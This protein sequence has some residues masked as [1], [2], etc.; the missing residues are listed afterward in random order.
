MKNQDKDTKELILRCYTKLEYGYGHVR[1][2][3]MLR[4]TVTS[5]TEGLGFWEGSGYRFND[6]EISNQIDD[7]NGSREG[8][9][10]YAWS[11]AFSSHSI[12]LR[13]AKE[14]VKTLSMIDRKLEAYRAEIGHAVTYGQ[15]VARIA[16]AIGAKGIMFDSIHEGY[17]PMILRNGESVSKIDGLVEDLARKVRGEVSQAA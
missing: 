7:H 12:E 2:Y 3:C 16:Q 4:D 17:E 13:D 15:Y 1:F 14:M 10:D 6:L 5:K 11:V 9:K 8:T